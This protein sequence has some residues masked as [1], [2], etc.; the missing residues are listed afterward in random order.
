M[1]PGDACNLLPELQMDWHYDK[2]FW[3]FG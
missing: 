2:E 1:R 3:V